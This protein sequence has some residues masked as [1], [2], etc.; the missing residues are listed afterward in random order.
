MDIFWGVGF[1]LVAAIYLGQ[2]H[3]GF[4]LRRWL[5]AALVS[6]WGL[7][8]SIHILR[9]NWG[10][11][12]DFRYMK[13]REEAGRSWWWQSLFRVFLLQG[14]ILWIVSAPILAA[15]WPAVPAR[16][17]GLDLLATAVWAI[18]FLFEA[19]GDW[20]LARFR[21]KPANRGLLMTTGLWRYSRHPNYFGD[22]VQWW[23]LYLLAAA[24]GG[25]WTVF[26]PLLMTFL[27][28]RVSGVTMMERSLKE[29]KPGYRQ[30]MES[31]NAFFPGP[32]H[33]VDDV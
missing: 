20:Q 9:R 17:A 4:V 12:E 23:G 26:S 19:L 10:K 33:Q 7:R 21:A 32:P 18:G 3:Q 13:W 11:K 16:I 24:A 25:W 27:L 30:Y 28:M 6:L 15:M 1:V 31:T 8:L 22:A 29:T 14:L 5:A 2:S